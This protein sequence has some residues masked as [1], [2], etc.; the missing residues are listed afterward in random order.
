M[1]LKKML[2]TIETTEVTITIV[3]SI[4]VFKNHKPLNSQGCEKK[5]GI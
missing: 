4:N 2:P 5:Y 3:T 1:Y